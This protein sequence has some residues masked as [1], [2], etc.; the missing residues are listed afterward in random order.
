M[1]G[2]RQSEAKPAVAAM[3]RI[4][5]ALAV[6]GG[7][8]CSQPPS[9]AAPG[10]RTN[11]PLTAQ[12]WQG[13]YQGPYHLYLRLRVQDE[14]AIGFWR[15]IGNRSGRLVGK[16]DGDRLDFAWREQGGSETA[17]AG[18]G[19][20]VLRSND[21]GAPPAIYGEWGLGQSRS[22]GS[23]WA[24]KRPDNPSLDG[25]EDTSRESD[26]DR[27]CPSCNVVDYDDFTR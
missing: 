3:R 23:W 14:K 20:F 13:V 7:V 1:H 2:A 26:E 4:G 9:A 12:A 25:T 24:L 8:A 21:A 19:Y 6:L 16:I 17:W 10:A 27:H 22:G 18:R 15:A 5:C 11:E